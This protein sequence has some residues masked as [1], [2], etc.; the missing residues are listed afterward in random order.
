MV[1]I[2][3]LSISAQWG[4]DGW[5]QSHHAAPSRDNPGHQPIPSCIYR[6]CRLDSKLHR[7]MTLRPPVS[8]VGPLSGLSVVR[9]IEAA[10]AVRGRVSQVT[11]PVCG[12]AAQVM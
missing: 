2:A 3:P 11:G 1:N 6:C 4:Q 8:S 7:C 5:A 9:G 10:E 12:S